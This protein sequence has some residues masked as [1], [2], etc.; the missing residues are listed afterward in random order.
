MKTKQFLLTFTAVAFAVVATAVEKPKMNVIALS[1]EKALIAI[2]NENP[3]YFELSIEAE[4]GDLVYYKESEK[5]ITDLRQVINYSNMDNGFYTLK[6]KIKDTYVSRDFEINN[7]GMI[8][9]E[10]KMEYAPHFAY[11]SD[12]LK[13]SYLNFDKENVKFK[14][15]NNGELVF[16]NKLGKEF[17]ISAGYDLSKLE[18]GKY[19][20]E[21]SSISNQFSYNIEK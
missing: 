16:E 4:N 2:E 7:N 21:V 8:V 19:E 14:I 3:A 12:V 1:D 18:S 10:S 17:V 9:G 6:L 15:Y 5:E 13:L 11:D 20:I